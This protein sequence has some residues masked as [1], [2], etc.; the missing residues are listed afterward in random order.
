M[1]ACGPD[2]T[3]PL[4]LRCAGATPTTVPRRQRGVSVSARRARSAQAAT[5]IGDFMSLSSAPAGAKLTAPRGE[6]RPAGLDESG[7][8]LEHAGQPPLDRRHA[9]EPVRDPADERG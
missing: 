5:A 8:R 7:A 6:P 3:K 2:G 9:L 1:F 4:G